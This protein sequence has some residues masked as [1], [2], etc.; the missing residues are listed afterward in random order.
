MLERPQL[1]QFLL[2][3]L[4]SLEEAALGRITR[5]VPSGLLATAEGED[6][7]NTM[8]RRQQAVPEDLKQQRLKYRVQVKLLGAVRVVKEGGKDSV[9]YVP[10]QRRLPHL[11]AKVALPSSQVL[12]ELCKLSKGDTDLG[13]YVLGEFVYSGAGVSDSNPVLRRMDPLLSVKFDIK[14]LVSRRSVVFARAGYG[15]SN[16]IKYLVAELYKSG[17]PKTEGG[18]NVGTLIF[19]ADGE[20]FWPDRIKHR[21]GLCDVPHLREHI[22]AFTNRQPSNPYYG[23]WKAGEVR[24]DIRDLP[25]RDVVGISVSSERQEQQNVL[26][27]K[28]LT[29]SSWRQLVDLIHTQ[30]LQASDNDIGRLMG[31]QPAQI[32]NSA[33][34]IAAARSNMNNIVRLLHDPASQLLSGTLQALTEGHIVVIDI[35]LLSSTAGNTI[36]GLILRR[37]FSHNQENFTGGQAPIPVV[38]VIEEAQSVLGRNLEESSPFVEWVKEGRKYDL[39]AIL[40]TQQPGS[41]A[42][43]LLSQAD[44][45][46]SFHLLSQGDAGV[47]GK[48]NS[49]YSDDILAHLIGE[50]IPGN[51]FM[52]SAPHQPFVLPVRV[53]SFEE[54]YNRNVKLDSTSPALDETPALKIQNDVSKR[55]DELANKLKDLLKGHNVKYVQLAPDSVGIV[56]G[57]LYYLIRDSKSPSD[58]ETE[59]QLMEPLLT[60][61]LGKGKV[62]QTLQNSR[63]Y[64][65][66][67][68]EDWEKALGTNIRISSAQ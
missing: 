19:D 10:S 47:L 3:E 39:G 41:L 25:P 5:F 42:S 26:K 67:S 58:Y 46:F 45:W 8:Q 49:H 40:V 27:L 55:H 44:N 53:R 16:L 63:E 48:Y 22:V 14:N 51:C 2:I 57:Q 15:K 37:I 60:I 20:Y 21:P 12:A 13:D 4:G 65:C 34:E 30:H 36:A 7:V 18:Q 9:V 35:S 11:G 31:Y 1:G 32:Q 33:A 38:A 62:Q 50:P 64:F 28:S 52:W 54:L 61:I 24:L 56:K 68:K 59:N 17:Q 66:A 43:E 6:Y 23:S 29:D